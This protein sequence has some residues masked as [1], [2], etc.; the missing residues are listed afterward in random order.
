M[1]L[2]R[3]CRVCVLSIP[4]F[5][6][7]GNGFQLRL[8]NSMGWHASRTPH[9]KRVTITYA[10]CMKDLGREAW[11][12]KFTI[13]TTWSLT[14]YPVWIEPDLDLI[15]AKDSRTWLRNTRAQWRHVLCDLV[16]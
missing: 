8:H 4:S 15:P 3:P 11:H 5:P 6:I 2:E 7:A 16:T 13:T 1:S 12:F 14:V 10:F 9:H